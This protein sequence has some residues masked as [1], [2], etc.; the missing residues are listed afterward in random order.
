ML[1][2]FAYL[3]YLTLTH[4]KKGNNRLNGMKLKYNGVYF[5]IFIVAEIKKFIKSDADSQVLILLISN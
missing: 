5:D 3:T 4:N 1:L 2:L